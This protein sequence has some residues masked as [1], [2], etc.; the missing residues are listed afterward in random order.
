[1]RR[2]FFLYSEATHAVWV[3]EAGL[4]GPEPA[5]LSTMARGNIDASRVIRAKLYLHYWANRTFL[6]AG[7][8][9]VNPSALIDMPVTLVHGASDWICPLSGAQ[10]VADAI[11]AAQ[12][13]V[14]PGAGHSPYGADSAQALR[15]S[16]LAAS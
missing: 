11:E 10:L 2:L 14:I 15:E 8:V 5:S 6:P 12:L 1:M 9:L 3:L 4:E 13:M 16:V 7:H